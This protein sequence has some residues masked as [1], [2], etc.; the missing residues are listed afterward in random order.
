LLVIEDDAGLADVLARGLRDAGHTVSVRHTGPDGLIEAMAEDY[1]ALVLDWML[2]GQD[3]PSVCRELR[4]RGNRTPVLMLTARHA[5]SDRIGGLDAGADD[6]LTKPFSFDELLA[7]LRV[8]A[9]RNGHD[10]LLVVG[11]LKLD[12]QRRTITRDGVG[13]N[14][15]AREFDLLA[16][17]AERVGRVVTRFQIFDDVWDG[18]T[19]LRSN[20]IDVHIANLRAKV[21]RP[22]GRQSIQT[23]R[24]VGFRLAD[25]AD[26]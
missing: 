6:Y 18:E 25:T 19:D 22:F 15:T 10:E 8:F 11:D 20:A 16:L 9:R 3:G 24:G 17:L 5:V 14:V 4:A 13:I 7:R 26:D 23:V 12:R 21:D 2:P 1:D